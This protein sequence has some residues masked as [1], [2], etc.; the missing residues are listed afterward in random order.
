MP[1]IVKR[2]RCVIRRASGRGPERECPSALETPVPIGPAHP[3]R[4]FDF[5]VAEAAYDG[6]TARYAYV[7]EGLTGVIIFLNRK[8]K[9]KHGSIKIVGI[10]P[11]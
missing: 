9:S 2:D 7:I 8:Y 5:R 11:H 10:H 3:A 4:R 1:R 6:G